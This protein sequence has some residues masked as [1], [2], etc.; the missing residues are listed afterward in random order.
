[1]EYVS[2]FNI[3]GLKMDG[4]KWSRKI[5]FEIF[6]M[7][8]IIFIFHFEYVNEVGIS[9]VLGVNTKISSR[10]VSTRVIFVLGAS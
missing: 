1:M 5:N 4:G 8:K 6:S 3:F 2:K 10:F 7:R 9:G